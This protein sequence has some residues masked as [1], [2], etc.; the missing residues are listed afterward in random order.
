LLIAGKNNRCKVS[1][2]GEVRIPFHMTSRSNQK[3]MIYLTLLII[4]L[5]NCHNIIPKKE[6][7]GIIV[8]QL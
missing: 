6:E 3:R 2:L 5:S 8:A 4:S 1:G 7:Y